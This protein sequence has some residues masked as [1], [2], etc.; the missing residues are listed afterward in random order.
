MSSRPRI[1]PT[2]EEINSTSSLIKPTLPGV[3]IGLKEAQTHLSSLLPGLNRSSSSKHFYGFVTG[4]ATP[5]A[6]YADHLVTEHD[7]NVQVHLPHDTIATKIEVKALEMVCELLGLTPKE[8]RHKTFTTGA[9]GSNLLGLAV[10][11]EYVLGEGVLRGDRG[12]SGQGGKVEQ[13]GS[14]AES[15]LAGTRRVQVLTTTPHSS[16]Y[17][18]AS[19]TGIGRGNVH[20]IGVMELG[21]LE[22]WLKRDVGS[23]IVISTS[24]V[25]TGRFATKGGMLREIRELADRY[26]AWIHIDAAFGAFARVLPPTPEFEAVRSGASD[27]DLAD[28]ITGDAHK[29]L[30]V[31]Y[32][33]GFFLSKRVDIA[34]EVCC[35]PNATYLSGG[36]D[37]PSPLNIGIE[38]SRRFRAFPVYATLLEFGREGY[39]NLVGNMVRL[40]RGLV[41]EL[42][43]DGWETLPIKEDGVDEE[44]YVRETFMIVCFR[45]RDE[46]EDSRLG[47]FV[48]IVNGLSR[49]FVG[50]TVWGGRP[51]VRIAVA[52]WQVDP[53]KDVGVVMEALREG[54]EVMG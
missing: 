20:D 37:V 33:C 5:S 45:F 39:A 21:V 16:I 54:L 23:I 32:D 11:R 46:G 3:G 44:E 28:S 49:V 30:N 48:E 2:K 24:E 51:A 18:A 50:R 1:L 52:N 38:N 14:I 53:E 22:G 7:Q 8:W 35:N 47:R 6:R 27:L 12:Q 9:M 36:G 26:G 15:G 10:G 31:P 29:I 40:A 13:R 17:K 42:R 19:L 41:R 25:N 34:E 43:K 4:G